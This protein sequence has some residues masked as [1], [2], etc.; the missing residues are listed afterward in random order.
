MLG[1]VFMGASF[2]D[3]RVSKWNVHC[4]LMV[5]QSFEYGASCVQTGECTVLRSLEWRIYYVP[6]EWR[7]YWVLFGCCKK[8]TAVVVGC[9]FPQVLKQ[10]AHETCTFWTSIHILKITHCSDIDKISY[11]K[12]RSYI[13]FIF[14]SHIYDV[15]MYMQKIWMSSVWVMTIK[16]ILPSHVRAVTGE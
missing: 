6:F 4:F 12:I 13:T 7:V 11:M 5:Q 8:W 15:F 14:V 10:T 9:T 16:V 3:G 2:T 1:I